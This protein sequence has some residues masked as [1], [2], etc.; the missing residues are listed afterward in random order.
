MPKI[1]DYI[2]HFKIIL[3]FSHIWVDC[4]HSLQLREESHSTTGEALDQRG[5]MPYLSI[6]APLEQR[7]PCFSSP[8]GFLLPRDPQNRPVW[9]LRDLH[10]WVGPK[11]LQPVQGP[12]CPAGWRLKWT[13]RADETE[14]VK[15]AGENLQI[16][17][18]RRCSTSI[19]KLSVMLKQ[20]PNSKI[21]QWN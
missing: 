7:W 4:T 6:G 15:K 5:P 13:G 14:F 11:K 2:S 8:A 17:T 12:L 3:G 18:S 9:V 19:K 1:A 20:F 21:Q 16:R 10:S